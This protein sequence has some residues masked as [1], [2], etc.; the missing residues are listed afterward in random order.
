MEE[1]DQA[2]YDYANAAAVLRGLTAERDGLAHRLEAKAQEVAQALVMQV[3][4]KTSPP[5]TVRG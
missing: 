1:F 3:V 4:G 5:I 2:V